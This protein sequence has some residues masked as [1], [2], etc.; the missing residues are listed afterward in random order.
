M[1]N[2]LVL[3]LV[4][5]GCGFRSA[6]SGGPGDA[7]GSDAAIDAPGDGSG[8]DGAAA[9]CWS[10]WMN[11]S[12]AIDPASVQEIMEL[13]TTADDR[14]PWISDS[15]LHMY[16]SR[17][18]MSNGPGDIYFTSRDSATGTFVTPNP[19]VELNSNNDEE[20]A[21]LTPD[22]LTIAVSTAHDGPL[23][24]HMTTRA[25]DKPF[26]TPNADHLAMVNAKGS[27]HLDPFLTADQLRLYWAANTQPN[28]RLEL[29]VSTR[30][31]TTADFGPPAEIAGID[32][33]S[34]NVG[35][36]ALY[37]GEQLLVFYTGKGSVDLMYATRLIATGSFGV[38]HKVPMVNT[39][40][41]EL[42]PV[43][44]P[45]GC[46]LYFS[47]DRDPDK[48]FHLFHARVTP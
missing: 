39:D 33:P 46:E 1:R 21:W 24:I 43:L 30:T 38:Q 6:A 9:D 3:C 47:S 48:R 20:R 26:G 15:G 2:R 8:S 35:S 13:S 27:L 25:D 29:L 42:D 14:H 11:G 31:S 4:L 45:D 23:Q 17:A 32:D 16:F 7:G 19:V 5:G 37:Q 34:T 10:H 22:E 12:V 36:P 40:G 18:A 44:S 41:N 28:T